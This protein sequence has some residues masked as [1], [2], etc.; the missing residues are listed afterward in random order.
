M[1]EYDFFY[2]SEGDQ[3]S[4]FRIPRELITNPKFEKLSTDAKL[5][6]GLLLDRMSLSRKNGWLDEENR[7]YIIFTLKE[8]MEQLNRS[9]TTCS[10]LFGE[11]EKFFLITKK[12]RGLGKPAIIYLHNIFSCN[13][14]HNE[15]QFTDRGL[16]SEPL[17]FQNVEVQTSNFLQSRVQ[18]SCSQDFQ[19][20]APS[21]TKY[22]YINNSY[23]ELK[24]PS[25][26]QSYNNINGI[27][28]MD[29]Y[30]DIIKSNIGYEDLI[31]TGNDV[32]LIDEIVNLLAETVTFNTQNIK[33]GGNDYPAE[34]VKS[35][36]LKLNNSDIEYVLTTLSKNTSKIRNIRGYLLAVLYNSKLTNNNYY[37]AEVRH[38]MYGKGD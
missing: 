2:G 8:A 5:L 15:N 29:K 14:E 16:E 37:S 4:F 26:N 35:R 13:E 19:N 24:N 36:F 28:E 3:F 21:Y 20:L 12:V 10:K 25:I 38:D 22:N 32:E 17:G 33:I 6:Y 23:T 31:E 11:L 27:D 34:V 9:H 30:V 18:A 1:S 7:V